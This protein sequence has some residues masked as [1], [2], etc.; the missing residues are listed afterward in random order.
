MSNLV[1]NQEA[2]DAIGLT[3]TDRTLLDKIRGDR[4]VQLARDHFDPQTSDAEVEVLRASASVVDPPWP[5]ENTERQAIR[6]EFLRWLATDPDAAA[7][8]A[9]KGIRAFYVTIPGGLDFY[10]Y[11]ITLP[12]TFWLSK[13]EGD[14]NLQSAETFDVFVL[15]SEVDGTIYGDRVNVKGS[16][17]LRASLISGGLC[18][19]GAQIKGDIDCSSM[20]LVLKT[21][22]K[23]GTSKGNAFTAD[24]ASVDGNVF[25]SD[26]FHCNGPISL[27]CARI[28]GNLN[29]SGATLVSPPAV[30]IAGAI[31]AQATIS[32]GDRNQ[33]TGATDSGNDSLRFAL[34][35]DNARVD[36]DVLFSDGFNSSDRISLF[37]AQIG[38]QLLFRNAQVGTETKDEANQNA[39]SGDAKSGTRSEPRK[40]IL[41]DYARISGN[42]SFRDGFTAHGRICLGS[43]QVGKDLSFFGPQLDDVDCRGLQVSGD[44]LWLSVNV[45]E[46]DTDNPQDNEKKSAGAGKAKAGNAS[47]L[48]R[49]DLSDASLANLHDDRKSWPAAEKLILDGCA[50]KG[51][52][53]HETPSPE[54]V[55]NNQ[56]S[57][58][59]V[60]TA[61]ERICWLMRQDATERA[62]PQPWIQ[63][64]AYL[65]SKGDHRG[66]K[67]VLYR[68]K[69]LRGPNPGGR[70]APETETQWSPGLKSD[71]KDIFSALWGFP[72]FLATP[73]RSFVKGFA[74][75]E[76]VPFRILW[77]ITLLL[78]AGTA[79]FGYAAS[80]RA[81]APTDQTIYALYAGHADLPGTYPKLNP[82]IY[83][84]ENSIPLAKFGQED[85][86]APDPH[87]S[88]NG[89]N[90]P[91]KWL[92]TNYRFLTWTRW[93][94]ILSGWFQAAVLA[95][96]LSG[97]FKD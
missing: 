18:L 12:L 75:L 83:A 76:E 26:Q 8:I 25:L 2:K 51:L 10:G 89:P 62:K 46:S 27:R 43:A 69:W 13:I 38:G 82:L 22:S 52:I 59:V 39:K 56:F 28:K 40:I 66:A 33:S 64:A 35:A 84:F 85:K 48:V 73:I 45:P 60:A 91:W 29:C 78:L 97:L 71:L 4:L 16:L 57:D 87:G 79:I 88:Y 58:E 49:L 21:D 32:Q 23:T 68:L 37:S 24:S 7:C 44:F 17:I 31:D 53:L 41:A 47:A 74:W 30:E 67:H 1:L 54:K 14:I 34:N 92:F 95:A 9:P 19:L 5:K 50:Y 3:P 96:A 93:L 36:G 77:S 70:Q 86:W 90:H 94:L 63:L 81:M 80:Q 72:Q 55:L 65:D 20:E 11:R 42:V 6:P 15:N 61:G